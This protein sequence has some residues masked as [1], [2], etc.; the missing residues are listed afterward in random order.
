MLEQADGYTHMT[1]WAEHQIDVG[2][3]R[4]IRRTF[5]KTVYVL[6]GG[7]PYEL[8]VTIHHKSA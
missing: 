3:F 4:Q 2:G 7:L 6:D 8:R 5:W 1:V